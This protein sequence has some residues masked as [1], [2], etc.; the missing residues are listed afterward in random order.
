MN[1]KNKKVI[2]HAGL[3]HVGLA[4]VISLDEYRKVRVGKRVTGK[5]TDSVKK[6]GNAKNSRISYPVGGGPENT[7]DIL[8]KF[9]MA[10]YLITIAMSLGDN[11]EKVGIA[12]EALK[13]FPDFTAA[14][15]VLA[16]FKAING[17]E[18]LAYFQKGVEAW[19]RFHEFLEYESRARNAEPDLTPC[20]VAMQ[21]VADSLWSMDRKEESLAGYWKM[22][23]LEKHDSLG[24]RFIIIARL[25]EMGK[26]NEF[27]DLVNSIPSAASSV[28]SWGKALFQFRRG[29]KKMAAAELK[30]ALKESPHVAD[31]LLGRVSLLFAMPRYGELS[32][33][34]E[35]AWA[36]SLLFESWKS[37]DGAVAW[38]KGFLK[39]K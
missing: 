12:E 30:T 11:E 37:T 7:G 35:Q 4:K 26:N 27:N 25:L 39:E 18:R 15:N 13:T 1:K 2:S 19:D 34:S 5:I 3:A 16:E 24:I 28:A 17:E 14:Y 23:K 31:Y 32:K 9:R 20:F 6:L 21:G 10:E 8:E 29:A 22:L 38:L 36:A 33:K